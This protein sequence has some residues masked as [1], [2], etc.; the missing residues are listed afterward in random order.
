MEGKLEDA[1]FYASTNR[2]KL[3]I[4]F[5][6]VSTRKEAQALLCSERVL[7]KW[8]G[9]KLKHAAQDIR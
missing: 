7:G 6:N 3:V 1:S 9:T 4:K 5:P 2:S 8:R